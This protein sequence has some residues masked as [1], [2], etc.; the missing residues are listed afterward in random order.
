M[1]KQTTH[2]WTIKPLLEVPAQSRRRIQHQLQKWIISL[3]FRRNEAVTET[4]AAPAAAAADDNN[5]PAMIYR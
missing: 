5:F 1:H 2:P 4:A 3:R